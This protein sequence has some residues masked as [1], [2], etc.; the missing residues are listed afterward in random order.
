[1]LKKFQNELK[2]HIIKKIEKSKIQVRESAEK[3]LR[4][5]VRSGATDDDIEKLLQNSYFSYHTREELLK[6]IADE[7]QSNNC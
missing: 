1:M 2:R 4:D 6:I 3:I 7:R 5:S